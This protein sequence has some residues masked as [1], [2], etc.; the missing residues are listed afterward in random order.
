MPKVFPSG[1]RDSVFR[2]FKNNIRNAGTGIFIAM[3]IDSE[4]PVAN[5]ELT[6]EHLQKQDD[7]QKPSAATDDQV[8]LMT[9]CMET[10]IVADREA[11]RMCFGRNFNKNSLPSMHDLE[12]RTP[13]DVLNSLRRATNNR[14]AKGEVSFDV[15]GKLNPDA[16]ERHLPSFCRMRRIL[17]HRLN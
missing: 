1:G 14:Y 11:L 3:L 7:W 5:I 9:T 10:W 4:A 8:F 15:I 12:R 6:W 17:N 16:L 13:R 2:D